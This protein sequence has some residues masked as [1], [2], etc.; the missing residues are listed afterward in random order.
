[1]ENISMQHLFVNGRFHVWGWLI[2]IATLILVIFAIR[3]AYIQTKK[4][5][6]SD[7]EQQKKLA[8]LEFNVRA[9]RGSQYQS[10]TIPT[11]QIV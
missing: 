9:I 8:E 11:N 10:I 3:Q 6:V 5:Q 4:I 2:F 1:M 7:M